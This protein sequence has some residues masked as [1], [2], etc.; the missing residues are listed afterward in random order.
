MR[1][2]RRIERQHP[3]FSPVAFI[4][5]LL[6]AVGLGVGVYF[7]GGR[8]FSPGEL[9]AVNNSGQ[10]LGEVMD[11]AAI[12][13]DCRQCHVPFAGIKAGR[14]EACHEQ[15]AADRTT[16]AKLHGRFP[17]AA[18][19]DDC[20][21]EHRGHDYDLKTAALSGFDHEVTDFTL[22]HHLVDYTEQPLDCTGCHEKAGTFT[23][24]PSGCTLCH[25]DAD[26]PFMTRHMA[27]YGADCLACH[28]GQD[29]LADFDVTAHA[30]V[31]ALTG[32]HLET[33]CEDCH[34][35]G[36]FA[37]KSGDCADCHAEPEAHQDMFGTDC[38]ACHT[39]KGW[40]PAGMDGI[41]FDHAR[42]T[43][44]SLA[45]HVTDYDGAPFACRTCHTGDEPLQ[46]DDGDCVACHETAD[47]A[48][49]V[50]HTALF[51]PSCRECHDGTGEMAQFDH[52]QVW[53]LTGQ[54]AAQACVACHV[55]QVFQGTPSEC[56]ACHEEPQI[57]LGIF[58]TD[59]SNC[60]ATE[61]W[62]PARLR[63]HTFPLDHGEQG[64]L[65]CNVCHTTSSYTA[66]DCTTCHEHNPD[67]VW[68]DH[69]ELGETL[70][71]LQD[72]VQ[73]HPTGRTDE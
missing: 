60:H 27:A 17:N 45:R 44:F 11:H 49:M 68:Q 51:G 69:D 50:E 31:F 73:C 58:G 12:G 61:A 43:G 67:Q 4:S 55:D 20:H 59:C 34:D 26:T 24:S 41:V 32:A 72:C 53:P 65:A 30:Q 48:F 21:L 46:V 64:E 52:A 38:V 6:L 37:K 28:D 19:C 1:Q 2:Y 13:D 35:G 25:Q 18:R 9:S 14:C 57:H 16:T 8:A 70:E 5:T 71:A 54:H 15:I 10:P 56:V 7:T 63:Q 36:E 47:P 22:V 66:Y 62:L 23:V 33:A 42:E 39:T 3:I 29:T 40:K